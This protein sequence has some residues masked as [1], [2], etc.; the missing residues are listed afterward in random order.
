MKEKKQKEQEKKYGR[1]KTTNEITDISFVL[2]NST[3]K[4]EKLAV[5]AKKD[6]QFVETFISKSGYSFSPKV[7]SGLKE[8]ISKL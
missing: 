7:L 2:K 6:P 5:V 3:Y 8:I 4:G 1:S